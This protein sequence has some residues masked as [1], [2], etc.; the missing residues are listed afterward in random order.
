MYKLIHVSLVLL[1]IGFN[2]CESIVL[3]QASKKLKSNMIDQ[4]EFNPALKGIAVLEGFKVEVVAQNPNIVNPSSISFSDDGKVFVLERSTNFTKKLKASS[5]P[6]GGLKEGVALKKTIP[7]KIKALSINKT[8]GLWE[9]PITL[10]EPFSPSTFVT[11]DSFIYLADSGSILRYKINPD[12]GLEMKSEIIIKGIAGF[13]EYQVNALTFGPD[14]WLY[15]HF[16]PGDSLLEGTDGKKIVVLRTGGIA[17]CKPDGKNLELYSTGVRQAQGNLSFDLQGNLFSVDDQI[18]SGAKPAGARLLHLTEGFDFGWHLAH[19]SNCCDPDLFRILMEGDEAPYSVIN[20]PKVHAT[21]SHAY[22]DNKLPQKFKNLF[23]VADGL[24]HEILGVF[25]AKDKSTFLSSE[26]FPFLR[27]TDP[28]FFPS[29]ITQG[30]DGA[31]YIVDQGCSNEAEGL[32]VGGRILRIRWQGTAT[33]PEI[34]LRSSTAFSSFDEKA[35]GDLIA[36]LDSEEN[37]IKVASKNALIRKG[38]DAVESLVKLLKDEDK[39]SESKLR[40]L[41]ALAHFWDK[42]VQSIC[43]NILADGDP[44]LQLLAAQYLCRFA[45]PGSDSIFNVL[46]KHLGSDTPELR[47]AITLA[48]GKNNAPGSAESLVN[49]ILFYEGSDIRMLDVFARALELTGK[50]GTERILAV[51]DTGV[52]KDIRK[53]LEVQTMMRTTAALEGTLAWLENQ[54]IS[55]SEIVDLL[56]S[57]KNQKQIPDAILSQLALYCFKQTTMEAPIKIALLESLSCFPNA[58]FK[59][60]EK[61]L[62]PC[63]EDVNIKTKIACINMI[64]NANIS[65]YSKKL[66][67]RISSQEI[68]DEEKIPLLETLA[69]LKTKESIPI[70]INILS[71]TRSQRE[72]LKVRQAALQALFIIDPDKASES[73]QGLLGSVL[74]PDTLKSEALQ[75]LEKNPSGAKVLFAYFNSGKC[76]PNLLPAISECL[77]K[78]GLKSSEGKDLNSLLL[79][80]ALLADNDLSQ[81]QLFEAS[82]K[83]SAS[84]ERGKETFLNA[85][86]Q[87]CVICHAINKNDTTIGPDLTFIQKMETAKIIRSLLDPAH[88]IN[89]AHSTFELKTKTGKTFIGVKTRSAQNQIMLATATGTISTFSKNEIA[90]LIPVKGSIMPDNLSSELSYRELLD[91]VFFLKAPTNSKTFSGASYAGQ[92]KVN[93]GLDDSKSVLISARNDGFF[94]LQKY[95]QVTSEQLSFHFYLNSNNQS[96]SVVTIT[97]RDSFELR[98]NTV[99]KTEQQIKKS[100]TTCTFDLDLNP[101]SNLIEIDFSKSKKP[102]GFYLHFTGDEI[103]GSSINNYPALKD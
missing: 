78:F 27:S 16:P 89:P 76:D 97:S 17:R 37:F 77:K 51:G 84:L 47:N 100:I 24:S 71:G 39:A 83:S 38:K 63:L 26:Y 79:K 48:M 66:T 92:I 67:S 5:W 33:D 14:G 60:W 28:K 11:H 103:N 69:V 95:S 54:N 29:Q 30:P 42:E 52:K 15:F 53:I 31:L 81:L 32:G 9:S 98:I 35:V 91:L 50:N 1:F 20:L 62:D 19:Q 57:L 3:A 58:S 10:L 86:N 18:S 73:I 21:S 64:K 102:E 40:A 93:K 72:S 61:F 25:P 65:S 99:L 74:F 46:L 2:P 13:N 4:G 44:N 43:E 87:S 34:P 88:E 56:K 75:L 96:K 90:S 94:D 85:N 68:Q 59:E 41:E 101:G 6:I 80:K 49:S 22:T 23:L 82:M 70:I 12:G 45:S 55:D 36:L 8:T 7:D